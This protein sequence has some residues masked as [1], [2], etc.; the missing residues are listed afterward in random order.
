[1]PDAPTAAAASRADGRQANQLRPF[2]TEP[3]A[4]ERPDGSARFSHDDTRLLVSVYGPVEAKRS[5]ENPTEAILDVALRPR[6]GLPGPAER[7][8]EQLLVQ[9]LRH[10]VVLAAYPRTAISV[11]VQVLAS[12]GSLLAVAM[13]G[14]CVALMHA[15]VPMRGMMGSCAIAVSADGDL[16]L[17]PTADEE[18]GAFA[19]LLTIYALSPH[20][21][22]IAPTEC[23]RL[24]SLPRL[25]RAQM[26]TQCSHFASGCESCSTARQSGSSSSPMRTAG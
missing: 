24:P 18:R 7:E 4:L 20:P 14:V 22:H 5:R 23:P 2:A 16:L 17:D 12:D 19:G 15:G 11:V 21:P 9:A 8:I 25:A 10:I 6:V 13:H 3:G 1:M 26:R